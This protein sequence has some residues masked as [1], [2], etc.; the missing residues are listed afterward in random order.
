MPLTRPVAA[1]TRLAAHPCGVL[2]LSPALGCKHDFC[3]AFALDVWGHDMA[4]ALPI[5]PKLCQI[6]MIV[7]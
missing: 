4:W 2:R 6:P 7:P 1:A 3:H 5:T